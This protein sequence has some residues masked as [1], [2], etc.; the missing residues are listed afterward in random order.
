[1]EQM[2]I[3]PV[4]SLLMVVTVI[5]VSDS[6]I[7]LE[8]QCH[9]LTLHLA[10]LRQNYLHLH[11]VLSS[12]KLHEVNIGNSQNFRKD[13]ANERTFFKRKLHILWI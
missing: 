5:R 6:F 11:D 10:Y 12:D 4:M 13:T 7:N 9:D 2:L 1:M 3:S 8:A